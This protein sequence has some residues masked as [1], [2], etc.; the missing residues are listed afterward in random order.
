M[1]IG[2]SNLEEI[3]S[4]LAE[5]TEAAFEQW[6]ATGDKT[7]QDIAEKEEQLKQ[8]LFPQISTIIFDNIDQCLLYLLRNDV[9]VNHLMDCATEMRTKVTHPTPNP[10]SVALELG[11]NL[12]EGLKAIALDSLQSPKLREFADTMQSRWY[13]LFAMVLF[14]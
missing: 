2:I 1:I 5:K 6:K 14:K 3:A 11:D 7:P 4:P 13:I 8:E 9:K 12:R 10:N